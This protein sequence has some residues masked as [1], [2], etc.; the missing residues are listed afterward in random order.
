MQIPPQKESDDVETFGIDEYTLREI[1]Q[2][3]KIFELEK[4]LKIAKKTRDD[5][6][7]KAK[8]LGVG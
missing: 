7:T 2:Q 6:E 3:K 5:L 8:E 1:E 4:R